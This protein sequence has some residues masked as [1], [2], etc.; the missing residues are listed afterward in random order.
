MFG[1]RTEYRTTTDRGKYERAARYLAL[2]IPIHMSHTKES[3]RDEVKKEFQLER[4]ILFSDAVFAIVIT[5]MAIEIHLPANVG[6]PNGPGMM[7]ALKELA[8]V[9][10]AYAASFFFIGAIWY[11]HLRL[12]SVLK[13]YDVGLVARNLLLLF[14]VGL[15]PFS[16][17]VV[18]HGH[19]SPYALT[20]YLSVIFACLLT[21]LLLQQY[22]LVQRPQ[23]QIR[24]DISEHLF[25][26]KRRKVV[27]ITAGLCIA[28]ILVTQMLLGDAAK[29]F[30]TWW[31]I[32]LPLSVKLFAKKKVKATGRP[33]RQHAKGD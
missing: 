10:I 14:C 28:L 32:I 31:I 20:V 30:A 17:T 13:D 5:L 25:A 1:S 15:F 18:T 6:E 12:F 27:V 19:G 7:A 4:M 26:L 23:L 3:F 21:Q 2:R 16:A 24:T 11:Q 29:Y 8:P 33:H 22:V 9:M